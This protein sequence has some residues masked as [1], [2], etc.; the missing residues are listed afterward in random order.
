MERQKLFDYQPWRRFAKLQNV[1]LETFQN[2]ES[3]EYASIEGEA[4]LEIHPEVELYIQ[5]GD[6][7]IDGY[8]VWSQLFETNENLN[9]FYEN[10]YEKYTYYPNK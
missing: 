5:D 8:E 9:D 1:N 2:I 7:L 10:R 6:K 4:S 3:N